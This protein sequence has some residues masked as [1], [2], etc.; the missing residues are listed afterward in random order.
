MNPI[1]VKYGIKLIASQLGKKLLKKASE[2]AER[3]MNKISSSLLPS[4]NEY[5]RGRN[6]AATNLNTSGLYGVMHN[7]LLKADNGRVAGCAK[8]IDKIIPLDLDDDIASMV[9]KKLGAQSDK[10]EG[11]LKGLNLQTFAN[12]TTTDVRDAL[13][14]AAQKIATNP[15]QQNLS[16]IINRKLQ[17]DVA[18]SIAAKAESSLSEE[19][20]NAMQGMKDNFNSFS[21]EPAYKKATMSPKP[22][23]GGSS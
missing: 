10:F 6:V 12:A 5:L 11:L 18:S 15:N 3:R 21:T 14:N 20:K 19:E 17:G 7:T 2:G 9:T 8:N 13:C 4:D 23:F 22:D 16:L 1:L